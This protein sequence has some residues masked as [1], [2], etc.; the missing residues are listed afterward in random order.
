MRR[1]PF[2]G[3]VDERPRRPDRKRSFPGDRRKSVRWTPR[4]VLLPSRRDPRQLEDL[5]RLRL[6]ACDT[7]AVDSNGT[8]PL[9]FVQLGRSASW[10]IPLADRG[11]LDPR[12]AALLAAV[13]L[14]A[15][16][17]VSKEKC[18]AFKV[19]SATELSI[20]GLAMA[21]R[22]DDTGL[23]GDVFEWSLLLGANG[24]D[25]LIAQMLSDALVLLDVRIDRPQAV[26]VAAERGRLVQY[27]PD[28][29]AKA[30]LATG[31]RG[32]P[33][34]VAK[35]L[36]SMDTHTWKADLLI[37]AE[38]RW[39]AT[40]L[41][42]NPIHLAKSLSDAAST[43]H[44]PRIGVTATE[45]RA[46]GVMRDPESG[47]VIVKVPV[48]GRYLA[49]SKVVLLDVSKAFTRHLAVPGTPLQQDASG[50]GRQLHRWRDRPVHEVVKILLEVAG[51]AALQVGDVHD[52]GASVDDARAALVAANPLDDVGLLGA[53]LI[54]FPISRMVDF[55]PID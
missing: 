20:L 55:D 41:K 12:T 36:T 43:Q 19:K 21:F 16:E 32:R 31:R 39:V 49:L 14:A 45:R 25:A 51:D 50:I 3:V 15:C 47:A 18:A 8:T 42:S 34:H 11:T 28:L 48:D 5:A 1:A 26:L 38:D 40:S 44:P 17:Q 54:S 22:D 35:L 23:V 29:P 52:T 6:G 30:A 13:L 9:T 4:R 24:A 27:S 10:D 53:P 46:A 2:A 33:P 7:S 37:G